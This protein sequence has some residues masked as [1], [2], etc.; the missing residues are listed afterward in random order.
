NEFVA[1]QLAGTQFRP[2]MLLGI[3]MVGPQLPRAGCKS[4]HTGHRQ[5][6]LTR[7]CAA[8]SPP[9]G[10]VNTTSGASLAPNPS[11]PRSRDAGAVHLAGGNDVLPLAER[12]VDRIFRLA[13]HELAVAGLGPD[14]VFDD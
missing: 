10:E 5:G 6:P 13:R 4:C 11:Y 14:L 7:R 8:T 9:K 2:Q 3:G 1:L 12:A